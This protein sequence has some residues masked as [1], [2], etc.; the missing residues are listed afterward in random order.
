LS[1]PSDENAAL[2]RFHGNVE[3]LW[4]AF[5]ASIVVLGFADFACDAP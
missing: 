2:E 5:A 4:F 3:Q 1:D